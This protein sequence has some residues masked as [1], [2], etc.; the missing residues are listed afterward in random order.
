[1]AG[2]DPAIGQPRLRAVLERTEPEDRGK[3]RAMLS[4]AAG[5]RGQCET[6]IR[7]RH[8]DR[9]LRYFRIVVETEIDAEDHLQSMVG[10]V[11][12]IPALKDTERKLEART[13]ALAEAQAMGRIGT[14]AAAFAVQAEPFQRATY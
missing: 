3:L 7:Y 2:F 12:D 10:A 8:P 13:E 6:M 14:A 1:M 5:R 4:E 9:G 11:H